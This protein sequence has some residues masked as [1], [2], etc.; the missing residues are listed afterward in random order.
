MNILKFRTY[1]VKVN[2]SVFHC[3]GL[4]A[5][6]AFAYHSISNRGASFL[7]RFTHSKPFKVHFR[8]IGSYVR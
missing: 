6:A 4:V 1:V 8:I 3:S 5:F 7:S 2:S